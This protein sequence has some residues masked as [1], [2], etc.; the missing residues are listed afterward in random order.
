MSIAQSQAGIRRWKRK[1]ERLAQSQRM[2]GRNTRGTGWK[3][4]AQ[5][6]NKICISNTGKVASLFTRKK[7]SLARKGKP[8]WNKGL[9]CSSETKERMSLA[10]FKRWK[11]PAFRSK[12]TG[13][14]HY[15]Y[16]HGNSNAPYG[17]DYTY[18][19]RK[20]VRTRDSNTCQFCRRG[21]KETR[22]TVHHID[23]NKN[24]NKKKNLITLC[25]RCNSRANFNREYWKTYYYAL[26]RKTRK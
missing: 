15:L 22:I 16:I 9:A 1:K 7:M 19:L 17:K 14:N 26:L 25:M 12:L 11:N 8:A 23:Y 3:H 20:Q 10:S 6:K 4:S 5:T 2:S 13:K 21:Q 18:R 24:H